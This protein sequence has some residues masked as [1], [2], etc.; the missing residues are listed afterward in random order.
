[1]QTCIAIF[2]TAVF[3]W[4][5]AANAPA[6]DDN[7]GRAEALLAQARATL[8][9]EAKLKAVQSLTASG[10]LRQAVNGSDDEQ[11]EGEIQFDYLL[12]DKYM[13]TEKT[14]IG[15]MAELTRVLGMNGDQLFR[16]AH[17][18]GGDG[19]VM[20]RQ[21]PNDPEMQAMQLRGLREELSRHLLAWFL[22]SPTN[23]E[24]EFSYAGEADTK[25]GKADAID[26]KGPEGFAARLFLDQQT[27]HPVM[28]SYRAPQPRTILIRRMSGDQDPDQM[29]QDADA[30]AAKEIETPPLADF[31]IYFDDYRSEDGILLPHH[32]TRSV[33]DQFS[34]EWTLNK[35]MINPSLKADKFK[36]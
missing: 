25:N 9:G 4:L 35:F 20:I 11:I 19:R 31:E 2:L 26:V 32:I 18:S 16:D 34:E 6:R 13:R 14:T 15:G 23:A 22:T 29:R 21:A 3:G 24:L 17:S 36:K 12:P 7:K 27:H 1:M 33:N 28:L 10:K 8:G 30:Q 5:A